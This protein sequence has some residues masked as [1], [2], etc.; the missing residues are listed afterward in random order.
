MLKIQALGFRGQL[1]SF[2]NNTSNESQQMR[3]WVPPRPCGCRGLGGPP[4]APDLSG[5]RVVASNTGPAPL[6]RGLFSIKTTSDSCRGLL[7]LEAART[8]SADGAARRPRA[9]GRGNGPCGP[10]PSRAPE[11]RGAAMPAPPPAP[12]TAQGR[13]HGD[14]QDRRVRVASA[15]PLRSALAPTRGP[16][17]SSPKR[18]CRSIVM[19][20]VF[21]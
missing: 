18:N 14:G 17:R 6:G 3:P 11:A 19:A 8:L 13:R 5:P 16:V 7:G 9:R 12:R 21:S 2:T 10:W 15:A 1:N 20:C 4:E